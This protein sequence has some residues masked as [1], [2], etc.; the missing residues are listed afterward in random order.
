MVVPLPPAAPPATEQVA[1]GVLRLGEVAY[2]YHSRERGTVVE[3]RGKLVLELEVSG[4][5]VPL[6]GGWGDTPVFRAI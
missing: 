4:L 6:T 3:H 5:R 2:E 1:A